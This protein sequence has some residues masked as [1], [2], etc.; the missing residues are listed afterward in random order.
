GRVLGEACGGPDRIP[1][2]VRR[3]DLDACRIVAERTT[4]DCH[5]VTRDD[6][7]RTAVY[8]MA[9]QRYRATKRIEASNGDCHHISFLSFRFRETDRER[10]QDARARPDDDIRRS[11]D[12]TNGSNDSAR[13]C[14]KRS[15]SSEHASRAIDRPAAIHDSPDRSN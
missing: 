7:S 11:C 15:T 2:A 3:G 12:A 1:E 4:A 14:A 13:V 5:V 10:S 8:G 9:A 6:I